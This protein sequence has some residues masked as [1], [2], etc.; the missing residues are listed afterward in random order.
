MRP[1]A[2]RGPRASPR[3]SVRPR[4]KAKSRLNAGDS[5]SDAAV[6]P[7]KHSLLTGHP[8]NVAA[9]E[10]AHD[11]MSPVWTSAVALQHE[12]EGAALKSAIPA[13]GSRTAVVTS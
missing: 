6:W 12:L 13:A 4:L 1:R 9:I 5:S 3:A 10:A 7:R 11:A 8:E 2:G